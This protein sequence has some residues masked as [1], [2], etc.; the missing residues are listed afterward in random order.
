M[1]LK[2]NKKPIIKFNGGNPVA[3]CNGCRSMMCYVSF[4][5]TEK[6]GVDKWVV[7]YNIANGSGYMVTTNIGD[8]VP[9]YCDKCSDLLS[10]RLN[11]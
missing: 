5:E 11:Q 10:I 2:N 8:D 3:L 7:R 4:V 6:N 1:R 9:I